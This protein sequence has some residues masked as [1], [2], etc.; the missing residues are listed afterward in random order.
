MHFAQN[1]GNYFVKMVEDVIGGIRFMTIS[2]VNAA[3]VVIPSY[4]NDSD[5]LP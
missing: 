2:A 3:N 5:T 4:V 1:L